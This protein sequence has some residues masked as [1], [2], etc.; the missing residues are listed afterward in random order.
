MTT[1]RAQ[2]FLLFVLLFPCWVIAYHYDI[3]LV[4]IYAA[5]GF[6]H[7]DLSRVYAYNAN[8]GRY[9]YPPVTLTLIYPFAY[10]SYPVVKTFWIILQ[11]LSYITFWYGF[12]K[13][14]PK[15]KENFWM[16]VVVFIVSIN[17]IHNNYQSNNIQLMLIAILIGAEVLSRKENA[18][19][20]KGP[21]A[22]GLLVALASWI[23]VFPAFMAVYY[24]LAKP[25]KA[26]MGVI[27]GFF[28][29][30]IVPFFFFGTESGLQLYKDFYNGVSTYGN[31]NTSPDIMCLPSLVERFFTYVVPASKAV[32]SWTTRI[33]SLG[34]A[35]VFFAIVY[36]SKR[37]GI[38]LW[39]AAMALTAF[40]NPSTRPHY[41]IFYVPAF[42]SAI[43]MVWFEKEVA[44][45]RW[46]H[47]VVLTL[48][49]LLVAFTTD[50]VLGKHLNDRVELLSLPTLGSALAVGW[51]LFLLAQRINKWAPSPSL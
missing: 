48:S 34:I 4:N 19:L 1:I 11:T 2:Y 35:G 13:L 40:L 44:V 43:Q 45:S 37:R 5:S 38:H 39:A 8:L 49:V 47:G 16:W 18:S 6:L 33:L 36:F 25:M 15:F 41:F 12:Y 22:A 17:P 28:V 7:S 3:D 10:V 50:A 42:A 46:A 14:Y 32:I 21:F 26:K 29:G 20:L 23:K 51:L 9:F 30:L 24:V 27:V 31:E